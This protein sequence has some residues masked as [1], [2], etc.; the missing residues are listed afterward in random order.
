MLRELTNPT[1]TGTAGADALEREPD[2]S[3]GPARRPRD[4]RATP[5][6]VRLVRCARTVMHLVGGLG[7][8]VFVFPWIGADTR[9]RS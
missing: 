8:T 4:D 2:H 5:T 9:N 6:L 3:S 7:T 1:L